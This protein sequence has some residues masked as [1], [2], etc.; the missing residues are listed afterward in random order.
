MVFLIKS[1]FMFKF[2]AATEIENQQER[3]DSKIAVKWTRNQIQSHTAI[4]NS[5]CCQYVSFE[6]NFLNVTCTDMLR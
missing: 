1:K 2:I 4:R 3:T 5:S 6:F